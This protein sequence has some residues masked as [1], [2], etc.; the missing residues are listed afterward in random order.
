MTNEVHL[1]DGEEEPYLIDGRAEFKTDYEHS[2]PSDMIWFGR[3]ILVSVDDEDGKE[4][5]LLSELRFTQ[6]NVVDQAHLILTADRVSD[7]LEEMASQSPFD[8]YGCYSH[9]GEYTSTWVHLDSLETNPRYRNRGYAQK[10]LNEYVWP[11]FE[12]HTDTLIVGRAH[13]LLYPEGSEKQIGDK[14]RLRR[15]W[16]N[17]MGFVFEEE[18]DRIHWHTSCRRHL[19]REST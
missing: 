4:D 15:F 1:K 14:A 17:K 11:F 19:H 9:G 8:E 2:G 7:V 5:E 13:P 6:I 10:L 12:A 18:R 3:F 16:R